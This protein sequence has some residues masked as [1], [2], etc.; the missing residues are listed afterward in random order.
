[1]RKPFEPFDSDW[2]PRLLKRG[3]KEKPI[4][5]GAIIRGWIENAADAPYALKQEVLT[6]PDPDYF[7]ELLLRSVLAARLS[8]FQECRVYLRPCNGP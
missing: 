1:M 2:L 5:S 7:C 3:G 6:N 4:L 8:I